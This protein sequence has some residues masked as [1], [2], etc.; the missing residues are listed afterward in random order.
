MLYTDA[1]KI[2]RSRCGLFAERFRQHRSRSVF[3]F[4]EIVFSP[5]KLFEV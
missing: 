3:L 2:D 5:V 4:E 1:S